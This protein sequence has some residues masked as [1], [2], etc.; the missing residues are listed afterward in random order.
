M[1][2]HTH[3]TTKVVNPMLLFAIGLAATWIL[4]I[5]LQK[6]VPSEILL[7]V[8]AQPGLLIIIF[9]CVATSIVGKYIQIGGWFAMTVCAG[10]RFSVLTYLMT[11]P[12]KTYPNPLFCLG[13]FVAWIAIVI[14]QGRK[15]ALGSDEWNIALASF[16]QLTIS[17]FIQALYFVR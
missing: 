13:A 11:Q 12:E 7:A 6:L 2:A 9:F 8:N 10:I 3:Q 1:K 4:E 5:V 15:H 17:L 14:W 16:A